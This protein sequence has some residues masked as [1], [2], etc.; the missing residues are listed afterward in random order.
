MASTWGPHRQHV[1]GV[2]FSGS[3]GRGGGRNL[4]A[5]GGGSI[6]RL[7]C[8]LPRGRVILSPLGATRRTAGTV[9]SGTH[10]TCSGGRWWAWFLFAWLCGRGCLCVPKQIVCVTN[11]LIG[12]L[13]STGRGGCLPQVVFK[14]QF[15]GS[16]RL[17]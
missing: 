3:C 14:D 16:I 11:F 13:R 6:R 7:P 10:C 9:A 12:W 8:A 5:V 15:V 2:P 17:L 4:R 1:M